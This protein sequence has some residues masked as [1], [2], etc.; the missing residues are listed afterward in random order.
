MQ[1]KAREDAEQQRLEAEQKA[2]DAQHRVLEI[3]KEKL[4]FEEQLREG[5]RTTRELLEHENL[6]LARS[7]QEA[8]AAAHEDAAKREVEAD[9]AWDAGEATERH[10]TGDM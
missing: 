2:A 3:E 6:E 10:E 7:S 9:R 4:R 8:V 1:L 5:E